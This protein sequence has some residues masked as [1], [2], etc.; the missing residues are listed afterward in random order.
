M[1]YRNT[2]TGAVVDVPSEV[3]GAWEKVESQPSPV[4]SETAKK[5]ETKKTPAK[6]KKAG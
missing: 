2:M 5:T 1:L 6:K 3:S 4:S